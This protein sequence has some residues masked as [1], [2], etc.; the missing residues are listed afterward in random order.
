MVA[1]RSQVILESDMEKPAN[2]A[3]PSLLDDAFVMEKF[4]EPEFIHDL[5][6]ELKM[7]PPGQDFID[8][9]GVFKGSLMAHQTFIEKEN[10]G[11]LLQK[12]LEKIGA[13]LPVNVVWREI[14]YVKLYLPWDI[15]CDLTRTDNDHPYYNALIPLHDVD[16]RTI[17]FNEI[18]QSHNHFWQ[19][20]Q[21]N[22][23]SL[24]PVPLE[25]WEKY[26]SMCWPEDREYLSLKLI[27][28]PQQAGQLIMFKRNL[29]HSSD[30]FHLRNSAPKYFLQVLIDLA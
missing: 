22:S 16:S 24:N 5:W 23:K 9:H 4:F 2:F 8:H 27:L 18:S 30:K 6:Q 12:T 15:H 25:T 13:Y 29:W 21:Q 14:N 26:L 20:K 3:T 1:Q 19:Y 10:I 7:L 17:I 11:P 28:P